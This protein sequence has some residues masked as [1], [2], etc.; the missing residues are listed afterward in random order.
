MFI[1]FVSLFS[2]LAV[3]TGAFATDVNSPD[4]ALLFGLE[5]VHNSPAR[6]GLVKIDRNTAEV[7]IIGDPN[8]I[9]VLPACGDLV[10]LDSKRG[11]LYYLG[12][13]EQG[14]TLAG[15]SIS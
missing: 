4:A 11:L 1:N 3:I 13:T 8:G 15:V 2:L 7:S 6:P 14:T 5:L 10:A 12:D 9:P